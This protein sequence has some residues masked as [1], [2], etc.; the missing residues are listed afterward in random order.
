[1]LYCDDST[2]IAMALLCVCKVDSNVWCELYI[3]GVSCDP[4]RTHI[5]KEVG[6]K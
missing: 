2:G 5:P 6:I 1:M 4:L 3:I